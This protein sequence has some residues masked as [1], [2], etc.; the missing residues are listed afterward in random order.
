MRLQDRQLLAEV[1]TIL[2]VL[3]IVIYH[4]R[5]YDA[6]EAQWGEYASIDDVTKKSPFQNTFVP[7][8]FRHY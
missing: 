4:E 5:S 1:V 2:I 3:L 7:L 6:K 8:Y